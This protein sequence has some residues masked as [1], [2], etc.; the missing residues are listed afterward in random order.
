MTF[1]P[2]WRPLVRTHRAGGQVEREERRPVGWAHFRGQAASGKHGQ[3]WA[4]RDER[5]SAR[6]GRTDRRGA[7]GDS[8]ASPRRNRVRPQRNASVDADPNDLPFGGVD[9]EERCATAQTSTRKAG[10]RAL[11][12]SSAPSAS[13]CCRR[14]RRTAGAKRPREAE[15]SRGRCEQPNLPTPALRGY[16]RDAARQA[17]VQIT[18]SPHFA[19][20]SKLDEKLDGPR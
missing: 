13:V 10:L 16:F 18:T 9:G 8:T 6:C 15:A 4:G 17:L 12:S 7:R 1:P 5:A 11:G 20:K 19:S 2:R 3:L 14:Q